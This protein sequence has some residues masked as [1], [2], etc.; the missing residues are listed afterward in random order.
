MQVT[1]VYKPKCYPNYPRMIEEKKS[2]NSRA[3]LLKLRMKLPEVTCFK[4]FAVGF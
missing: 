1:K 3:Q 2:W 4:M